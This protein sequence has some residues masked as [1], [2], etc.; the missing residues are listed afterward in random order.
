MKMAKTAFDAQRANIYQLDPNVVVIIGL[1]TPHG[2]EHVLYDARILEPLREATVLDMMKRG[3]VTPIVVRK[4]GSDAV[5]IDGR[6]RVMHAREANRRLAELGQ[7]LIRVPAGSPRR[8]TDTDHFETLVVLN[9]HREADGPLNR[10]RKAVTLLNRGRTEEEVAQLFAVSV[11]TLKNLLSLLDLSPEAQQ[12]FSLKEIGLTEA[13][14]LARQSRDDQVRTLENR[15]KTAARVARKRGP[16]R[17]ELLKQIKAV[18]AKPASE[19]NEGVIQ[20][21]QFAIGDVP[22]L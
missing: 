6:R 8:G 13:Y 22:A 9:E 15:P 20:A 12:A 21:L 14:S 16:S 18:Q 5:V 1:D 10:A 2:P 4:D 7:P 17:A 3:V 11:P 19:Y